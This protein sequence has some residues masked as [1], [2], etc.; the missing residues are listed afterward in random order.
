M[1]LNVQLITTNK[2]ANISKFKQY[3]ETVLFYFIM[4]QGFRLCALLLLSL[5]LVH[6]RSSDLQ[7]SALDKCRSLQGHTEN[8]PKN[9]LKKK[10]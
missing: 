9:I 6:A 8:H 1:G 5:A 2:S 3:S 7:F 10:K 4:S